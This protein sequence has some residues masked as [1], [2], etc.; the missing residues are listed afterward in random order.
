MFHFG[1]LNLVGS[2]FSCFVHCRMRSI[3]RFA[4]VKVHGELITVLRFQ[5]W[6]SLPFDSILCP[7]LG[8]TSSRF[9]L[10]YPCSPLDAGVKKQVREAAHVWL[11]WPYLD[12]GAQCLTSWFLPRFTNQRSEAL[13]ARCRRYRYPRAAKRG[14]AGN[15]FEVRWYVAGRTKG[16]KSGKKT[17]FSTADSA[18]LLL[19]C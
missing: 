3:P 15:A 6:G 12:H 14:P 1:C 2:C 13:L 18:L 9:W 11:W 5:E 17:T 7:A 4:E 19:V 8:L 16:D 10:K